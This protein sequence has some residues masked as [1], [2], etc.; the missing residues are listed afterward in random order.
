MFLIKITGFHF[1]SEA[2]CIYEIKNRRV[3]AYKKEDLRLGAPGL[4]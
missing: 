1:K 4:N 3:L 2:L